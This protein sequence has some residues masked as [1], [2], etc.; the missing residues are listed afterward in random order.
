MLQAPSFV[1]PGSW[2]ETTYASEHIWVTKSRQPRSSYCHWQAAPSRQWRLPRDQ[3]SQRIAPFPPSRGHVSSPPPMPK[4]YREEQGNQQ[5]SK[6]LSNFI[7]VRQ[8]FLKR[9]LTLYYQTKIS[10][11]GLTASLQSA[12]NRG[13][14]CGP[15]RNSNPSWRLQRGISKQRSLRHRLA[16]QGDTVLVD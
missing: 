4:C 16:A 3:K 15:E 11:I 9:K 13:W 2:A 14:P 12:L 8:Y 7:Q 1:D 6:S 10:E 5:L